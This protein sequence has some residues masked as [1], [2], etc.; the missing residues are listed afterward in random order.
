M[1]RQH[2]VSD[3]AILLHSEGICA[4]TR[5]LIYENLNL[6]VLRPDH[7][8]FLRHVLCRRSRAVCLGFWTC[9]ASRHTIVLIEALSGIEQEGHALPGGLQGKRGS[10]CK[11][12]RPEHGP[13]GLPVSQTLQWN[14]L[15]R[16]FRPTASNSFS[17][18][19][20]SSSVRI[21]S[22]EGMTLADATRLQ[23]SLP[24]R[25]R[26]ILHEGIELTGAALSDSRVGS[27]TSCFAEAMSGCSNSSIVRRIHGCQI[28]SS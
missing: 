7:F 5:L 4:A 15:R 3:T 13:N 10:A 12:A 9:M 20:A 14:I 28:M 6:R 17:S 26:R 2:Q 23:M 21:L 1:F 22:K 16:C 24:I 8:F 27:Q 19:I 11:K 18:T 25:L